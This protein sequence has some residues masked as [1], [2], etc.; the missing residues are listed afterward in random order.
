MKHVSAK[1]NKNYFYGFLIEGSYIPNY[2]DL[3]GL[4]AVLYFY[5]PTML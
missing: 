1:T 2:C 3:N 4:S 5:A